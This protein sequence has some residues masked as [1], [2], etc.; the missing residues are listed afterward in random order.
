MKDW[1]TFWLIVDST[2]GWL[3][4]PSDSVFE[5]ISEDTADIS[6][7]TASP[8]FQFGLTNIL[9]RWF[10]FHSMSFRIRHQQINMCAPLTYLVVRE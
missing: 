7:D 1:S 2:Q 5:E 6:G 10:S 3:P 9:Q 8:A 4:L